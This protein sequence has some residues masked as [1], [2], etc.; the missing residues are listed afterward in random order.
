MQGDSIVAELPVLILTQLLQ[1]A[2]L[3]RT[4]HTLSEH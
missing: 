4:G 2:E 1:E 3:D